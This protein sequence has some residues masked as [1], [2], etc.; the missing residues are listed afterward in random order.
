MPLVLRAGGTIVNIFVCS[1]GWGSFG[2]HL[3]EA[4]QVRLPGCA[5]RRAPKRLLCFNSIIDLATNLI[6]PCLLGMQLENPTV[7]GM[8]IRNLNLK[9]P[10]VKTYGTIDGGLELMNAAWPTMRQAFAVRLRPLPDLEKLAKKKDAPA[11]TLYQARYPMNL[12]MLGR[13]TL[14]YVCFI[15]YPSNGPGFLVGSRSASGRIGDGIS[16]Y[17]CVAS[18]APPAHS[19]YC[20]VSWILPSFSS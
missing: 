10:W 11:P 4:T 18:S 19:D 13:E 5:G 1:D 8:E 3:P 9:D 17:Y 20:F 2:S 15:L 14:D 6:Q 7:L 12:L 16:E